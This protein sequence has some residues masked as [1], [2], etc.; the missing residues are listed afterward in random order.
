MQKTIYFANTS[1]RIILRDEQIDFEIFPLHLQKILGSNLYI[2]IYYTFSD[3]STGGLG[4]S[5]PDLQS[6]RFFRGSILEPRYQWKFH[7]YF[8]RDN[9]YNNS[10]LRNVI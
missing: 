4:G 8:N 10:G 6:R 1:F 7:K 9:N 5:T 3:E 2:K